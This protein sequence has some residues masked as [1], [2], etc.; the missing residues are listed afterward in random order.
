M[1]TKSIRI[2]I[3]QLGRPKVEAIGFYGHGC[4]DATKGIIDKL[5]G[6]K[7]IDVNFK[8]EANMIDTDSQD[9]NELIV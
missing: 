1:S 2:T 3:D 8:P 4:Q 5:S 9:A 7:G 6:G